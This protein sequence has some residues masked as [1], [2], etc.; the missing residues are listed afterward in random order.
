[1]FSW[2]PFG[3]EKAGERRSDRWIFGTM[4][5]FGIIGLIA[6]FVLSVEKVHLLQNPDAVLSCSINLVLDCSTVM[7]TWQASVFG[8]PNSFIGLMG[9]SVVITVAVIGLSGAAS[10]LPRWFWRMAVICY[11]LGALFAY[12]LFFSSMYVIEVLCP[13]CLFVT[14]ATTVLVATIKHYAIREN[15][16]QFSKLT[17]KKL[18]R[19]LEKDVDKVVVVAWVVLLVALVFIKFGDSLFL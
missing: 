6:S 1:M 18:Q 8:F 14:L 15:I 2:W 3:K 10:A 16:W 4:L 9:Y 19:L 13:W 5:A 7:Q 17:N 12:W 11:A